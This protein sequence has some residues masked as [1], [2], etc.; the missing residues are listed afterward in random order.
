MA[1]AT[2]LSYELFAD[3]SE[4][5]PCGIIQNVNHLINTCPLLRARLGTEG[6]RN[7]DDRTIKWLD[8]TDIPVGTCK[9]Y[10]TNDD[11]LYVCYTHQGI[12]NKN[13]ATHRQSHTQE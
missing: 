3:E 10:H 11:V 2:I 4:W 9:N 13:C 1:N 7:L 5:Y 8:K 12:M 6:I